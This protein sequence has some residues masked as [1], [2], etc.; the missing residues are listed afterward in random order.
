MQHAN[1]REMSVSLRQQEEIQLSCQAPDIMQITTFVF[2]KC[3]KLYSV[4]DGCF[5]Q[6]LQKNPWKI[7]KTEKTFFV[8]NIPSFVGT[9]SF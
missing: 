8:H 1:G 3:S 4:S 5:C 2:P 9:Q 7:K 6:K